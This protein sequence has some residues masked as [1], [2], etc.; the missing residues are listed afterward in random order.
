M[1]KEFF[2]AGLIGALTL[3]ALPAL[4]GDLELRLASVA[5][6]GTPWIDSMARYEA[7]VE[8]ASGDAVDVQLFPSGQLGDEIQ[9]VQQVRRGRIEGA[10]VSAPSLSTLI[11]ELGMIEA[12]FLWVSP[13][14]LD[15]VMD[16]YLFD[17]LVPLFEAKDMILVEVMDVGWIHILSEPPVVMPG[18]AKGLKPRAVQTK[19]SMGFWEALGANPVALPFTDVL[20]SLQTGLVNGTDNEL[21]SIFFAEFYK[22]AQNLTLTFHSYQ[23]GAVVISKSWFDGLTSEQQAMIRQSPDGERARSRAEVRG[24]QDWILGQL[25][26]GGVAIHRLSPDQTAAWQAALV[27]FN[28][29]LAAELGGSSTEFGALIAQGKAAFSKQ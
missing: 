9:S 8:T 10:F 18:D 4:A 24:L 22:A 23:L 5:P 25:E 28:T 13:E 3:S 21:V 29:G 20:P 17:A 19:T 27:D 1:T 6:E 26:E 2:A 7:S 14:E 12:P 16:N 15:Y 11:P